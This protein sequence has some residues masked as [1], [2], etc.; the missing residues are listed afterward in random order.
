M[1]RRFA[2]SQVFGSHAVAVHGNR[3]GGCRGRRNRSA[4]TGASN[5][6]TRPGIAGSAKVSLT[7]S[8]GNTVQ[9][10]NADNLGGVLFR[11]VETGNGYRV[12]VAG[13]PSLN[14]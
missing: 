2:V 13:G 5:R 6:S 12:E 4:R 3:A 11:E 8:G 1:R 14:R 7:G 10:K 9:S